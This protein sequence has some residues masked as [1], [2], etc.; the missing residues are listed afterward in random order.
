MPNI[1]VLIET[2]ED[3]VKEA[4]FGVITAARGD[5]DNKLYAFVLDA[6]AEA[7]KS[8]MQAYGVQKV[9]EL[10]AESGE[11]ASNPGL[12]AEAL[13]AALNHF[14]IT[15][16][17]GLSSAKG[18]DLLA[19]LAASLDAPLVQDCV[20]IDLSAKTVTKSHFSGKTLAT[21][22]INSNPYFC[23]LRPNVVEAQTA[24][25]ETEVIRYQAPVNDSGKL[26]IKEVKQSQSGGVDL[27]EANIIITGG[28]PIA[29]AENYKILRE[30]ADIV[31]AAVGASRAA[32]DAGYAPH[33]MQVG[34]TGKTVSPKLYIGCGLSGSVQH[35]AG[36]KTSKIIVAIN[37][38]KDASIF[39][40]CDYGIVGDL[41]EVVPV[42][43]EVLKEQQ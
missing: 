34:Q 23:G 21:I 35:F 39:G 41:F 20:G 22:R 28:R 43:T 32:V 9:V 33:S 1:G 24:P 13:A 15:A 8:V 19:R 30:C 26:V 6:P 17:L 40:K 5:G 7:H 42:L 3:G 4:N 18:R 31:G 14:D 16:L 36:M 25:C 37:T 29:S 38:D 11:L 12:Q 2:G 27:T 10:T